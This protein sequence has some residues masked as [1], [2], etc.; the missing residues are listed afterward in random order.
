MALEIHPLNDALGAEVLGVNLKEPLSSDNI[1]EI[2]AAFL[3][4]HLLCLR[5]DPLTPKQFFDFSSHFGIPFSETT[6]SQWVDDLPQISRLDSTY[7]TEKDKPKNPKLNRRSGWHTDHSFKEFPPKAT[8]LHGHVIPSQAGHTCFCNTEKAYE[9]LP[10]DIKKR[11]EGLIAVHSYDT[12]R[13]PARAVKRTPKEIAETPDVE[14][15]LIRVHDETGNKAIYFNSNRT[16]RI[17]GLERKESDLLLDQIH[18][19]MTQ[20]KYRY[21]HNWSVGDV[22]IWDN[23]CLIHSVNVDYPI[24]EQR[25]HLR[26]IIEGKRPSSQSI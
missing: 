10:V 14:H 25:I 12:M 3:K 13:A 19:H 6:R 4:Y 9:D 15:P 23:R 11:V 26:T 18:K 5:G 21:D 8:I 7:K 22:V 24:G 20:K 17:V 2:K 1:N 16:D